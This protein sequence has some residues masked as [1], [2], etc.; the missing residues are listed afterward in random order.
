MR[1]YEWVSTINY[2]TLVPFA[3]NSINWVLATALKHPLCAIHI[4]FF[5]INFAAFFLCHY[6]EMVYWAIFGP[7]NW[8]FTALHANRFDPIACSWYQIILI[9]RINLFKY[10]FITLVE[11]LTRYY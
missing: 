3:C 1:R 6:R 7:Q 2:G 5:F 10:V 9:N 8:V 4:C 11:F